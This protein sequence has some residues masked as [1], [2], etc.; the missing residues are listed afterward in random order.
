MTFMMHDGIVMIIAMA[1]LW[2]CFQNVADTWWELSDKLL[3]HPPWL[4]IRNKDQCCL[5]LA[6]WWCYQWAVSTSIPRAILFTK[7]ELK[8][9]NV[10]ICIQN[11]Q[12][13]IQTM[14][15]LT[16]SRR[17]AKFGGQLILGEAYLRLA[18]PCNQPWTDDTRK[19]FTWRAVKCLAFHRTKRM[20]RTYEVFGAYRSGN[21]MSNTAATLNLHLSRVTTHWLH[22]KD[23]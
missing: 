16:V 14:Q 9:F 22:S 20:H 6:K 7:I 17:S 11:K 2:H 18:N 12:S 1:L 21:S 13:P 3:L 23:I 4:H 8:I 5:S 19:F 15:P 10:S